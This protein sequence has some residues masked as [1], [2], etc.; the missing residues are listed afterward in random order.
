MN[1]LT[2]RTEADIRLDSRLNDLINQFLLSQDIR[3]ISKSTY[4]RS[5]K[6]FSLWLEKEKIQNPN[7][8]TILA[9]KSYLERKGLSSATLSNYIVACRRFFEWLEGMKFYPNITKGIKGAKQPKGFK[10]DPLILEQIHNLLNSIDRTTQEGKRNF[11]L[12]NL[13]IR[14]GIRSIEVV[15]ANVGDISQKSGEATL[16]I[17]G[18]GR[19]T[20]DEFVVLTQSSLRPLWAYLKTRGN[21]TDTD[22]LFASLSDRNFG[23]RLTTR[24][25]SGI[26]KTHLRKINLNSSR[27]TG[28]SLRHSAITLS[29]I[30]G[31]SIEEARLL[32]RHS[33]LDTTLVYAHHL[34]RVKDAPERKIDAV[35]QSGFSDG[36][37]AEQNDSDGFI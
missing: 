27:L 36:R 1:E 13:M 30:G 19:D 5:L 8:E 10:R 18:K 25:I 11:A 2:I 31:C 26:I 21:V 33:S 32:A 15:R 4:K 37:E 6:Q 34:H 12:I 16:Y 24:S 22:P 7:R 17:W 23:K 3:E 20:R 9:Y 14:T 35:L 29:L 28:H